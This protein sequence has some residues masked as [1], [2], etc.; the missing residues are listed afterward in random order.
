[1]S[2][3]W[4]QVDLFLLAWLSDK[5]KSLVYLIKKKQTSFKWTIFFFHF[6][7]NLFSGPSIRELSLFAILFGAANQAAV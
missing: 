3:N 6:W 7:N 4:F 2:S 1:M 5:Q